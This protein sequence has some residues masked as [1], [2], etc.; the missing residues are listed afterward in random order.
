MFIV[1]EDVN[2]KAKTSLLS[3][4]DVLAQGCRDSKLVAKLQGVMRYSGWWG[5]SLSSFLL[6]INF[7]GVNLSPALEELWKD[8]MFIWRVVKI[9]TAV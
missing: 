9:F 3:R 8:L 4:A 5:F 1:K 7:E 2:S 6:N